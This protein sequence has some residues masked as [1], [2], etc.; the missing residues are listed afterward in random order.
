MG[1]IDDLRQY[2]WKAP[3][4]QAELGRRAGISPSSLSRFIRD[5]AGLETDSLD[6]LA[7]ELG[8]KLVRK[9]GWWEREQIYFRYLSGDLCREHDG[10]E[11]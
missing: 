5:K 8:L 2:A 11:K 10:G 1:I 6:R 9:E 4:R 3:G 7:D